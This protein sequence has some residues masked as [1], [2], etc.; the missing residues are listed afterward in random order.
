MSVYISTI[1]LKGSSVIHENPLPRF[2]SAEFDIKVNDDGSFLPEHKTNAGKDLAFRVLPYKMQDNYY[3][4]RG[5]CCLKTAILENDVM[6]AVFLPDFGGRL[7]SLYNKKHK[8]ELLFKNPVFQPANIAIRNAWISGGIEWNIGRTGHTYHTCSPVFFEKCTDMEGDEFLRMFEYDRCEALCFEIEFRLPEGSD[9]LYA[10]IKIHNTCE[11]AVPMY[12]WTNIAVRETVEMRILSATDEVIFQNPKGGFGLGKMPFL[13]SAPGKDSSFPAVYDRATEYFFQTPDHVDYPWEAAVYPSEDWIFT[14]YSTSMLKYRKMFAWGTHQGGRKW[15]D[16]LSDPGLGDYVEIQ[17][18][19][20]RTQMHGL[21]MPAGAVWSFNQAFSG[22]KTNTAKNI[23]EME[24]IKASKAVSDLF[25]RKFP[26]FAP[27]NKKSSEFISYGSGW[28]AL[29]AYRRK[30]RGIKSLPF[31]FPVSSIKSDELPWLNLLIN[32]RLPE[33]TQSFMTDTDG[34]D[35]QDMLETDAKN[36]NSKEALAHLGVIYY[37]N[38]KEKK[39]VEAWEK[40]LPHALS[41]RNLSLF[42]INRKNNT[43]ALKLMEKAVELND[44]EAYKCE[45]ADLLIKAGEYQKCWELLLDLSD[46]APSR[47][48]IYRAQCAWQT[49]RYNELESMFLREYSCIR[50]G[51]T[52]LT[53]LWFLWAKKTGQENQ[54]DPPSHIDFRMSEKK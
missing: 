15:R 13:A 5:V 1:S 45:Y 20:A 17:A 22:I 32:G 4:K 42:E 11:K 36:N 14:E 43:A 8:R 35:W 50:E 33:N 29:E 47:M 46:T 31:N 21:V 9:T 18:G 27:E 2:R 30:L 6:T 7:Y 10:N 49:E 12:W 40:S 51:E 34:S 38:G 23:C 39:A 48:W 24:Y 19:L 54:T 41:Y 28:G 16:F 26:D 53:D 44:S 37:E 52:A 3:R 25:K